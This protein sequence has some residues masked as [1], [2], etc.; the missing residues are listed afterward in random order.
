[1]YYIVVRLIHLI[2]ELLLYKIYLQNASGV[3]ILA[4]TGND[5][6]VILRLCT[7]VIET[8]VEFQNVIKGETSRSIHGGNIPP[9]TCYV[10]NYMKSMVDFNKTITYLLPE[11]DITTLIL[12]WLLRNN[13]FVIPL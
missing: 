7:A 4:T 5:E 9:T 8:F 11:A 1:M 10:M 2:E 6:G 12:G 3:H 13:L